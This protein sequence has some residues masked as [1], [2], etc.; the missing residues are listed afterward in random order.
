[1]GVVYRAR[2]LSLDRPVALKML[3]SGAHADESARARFQREAEAA[4]RMT[5]PNVV[6]I[7]EVGTHEGLP[8]F[9]ME[10]IEGET[11]ADRLRE[12]PLNPRAAAQLIET[13]ARAVF[14]AHEAGI[15]HRDL[16]PA[17]ILLASEE[18]SSPLSPEGRG[19]KEGFHKT[20]RSPTGCR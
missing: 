17:N 13:L 2:Q 3:L 8:F 7:Y 12:G 14:A 1:M 16:K 5:H 19:E 9:S 20:P 11:L 15:L 10:L 6:R 4:A 18:C